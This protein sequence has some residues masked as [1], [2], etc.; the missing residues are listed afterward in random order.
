MGGD[1]SWAGTHEVCPD[2]YTLV[3][4]HALFFPPGALLERLQVGLA[5]GHSLRINLPQPG[6]RAR[7]LS[8]YL[9]LTQPSSVGAEMMG[10][11]VHNA[12][13]FWPCTTADL[14]K[15]LCQR[16]VFLLNFG[17]QA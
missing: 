15:S 14:G 9:A 7:M 1:I 3:P 16:L 4:M 17:R 11:R 6:G 12:L 2:P 13:R 10:P 5:P 8:F